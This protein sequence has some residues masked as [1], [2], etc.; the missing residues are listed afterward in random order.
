[1]KTTLAAAV[2]A[3][4]SVAAALGATVAPVTDTRVPTAEQA[5]VMAA[6][7]AR[8]KAR[9]A[10]PLEWEPVAAGIVHELFRD[11][12]DPAQKAIDARLERGLGYGPSWTWS[13]RGDE[14]LRAAANDMDREVLSK[15]YT[16]GAAGVFEDLGVPGMYRVVVLALREPPV[17]GRRTA[18]G[19][20]GSYRFRCANCRK[21]FV[22]QMDSPRGNSSFNCDN[23]KSVL[24]PYL[25]DSKGLLHWPSWYAKPFAPFATTNPFLI[26][27][28]V[29][30]KVRYDHPRADN[31]VQ[32]WQTAE[33]TNT[34]GTG[35][36]RDTA[37]LLAA[38]LRHAGK[39]AR[40]VSG[41]SDNQ[42]HAWV[43][44]KDGETRYLFESAIDG[45]MTR[46]YPPRLEMAAGYLPTRMQFDDTRVWLNRGQQRTRDYDS[47]A[48]WY[49]VEE[50]P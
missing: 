37:V 4:A 48:I 13:S 36:C 43:V 5:R 19:P 17:F 3:V 50:A 2:L 40:V 12:K 27:Q 46:R 45:N 24:V 9:G 10:Q 28:W 44:L 26:W 11:S 14:D 6:L 16:H 38:W 7:N 34:L 20:S 42:N 31:N 1:V 18:N 32:G 39:E 8:R 29:N 25:S 22:Y 33:E 49:P 47:P 21:E 35:V 30:Q 15:D 41:L 23:C